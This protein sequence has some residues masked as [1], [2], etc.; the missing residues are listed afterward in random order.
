MTSTV[1]KTVHG[2]PDPEVVRRAEAVFAQMGMTPQQAIAVLYKQTALLGTFPIKD[3]IPNE[4]T[5]AAIE[6]AQN[7][8]GTTR[9]EGVAEVM[10]E[11]QDARVNPDD[12]MC[13][14]TLGCKSSV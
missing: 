1:A 14:Y 2:H 4:E 3:F 6:S 12:G 5:R 8:T 10:A 11:F 9:Y 7:S 13:I